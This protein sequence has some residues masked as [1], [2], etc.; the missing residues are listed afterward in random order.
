MVLEKVEEV[1]EE[2]EED[3]A[4]S[5]V[6]EDEVLEASGMATTEE[7]RDA[8]SVRHLIIKVPGVD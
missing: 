2:E 7:A 6:E 4:V 8:V 1:V 3:V 5:E